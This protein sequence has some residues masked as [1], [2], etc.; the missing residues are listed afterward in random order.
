MKT[1]G[2]L[3]AQE[4]YAKA[5]LEP[6]EVIEEWNMDFHLGT[7]LCY[8]VRCQ[9]KGSMKLDLEKAVWYLRRRLP[10]TDDL[11]GR[12][13]TPCAKNH[14]FHDQDKILEAWSFLPPNLHHA[15]GLLLSATIWLD[16]R[17][18]ARDVRIAIQSIEAE[19]ASYKP[20]PCSRC[21]GA[22]VW[23]DDCAGKEYP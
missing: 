7:A 6:I 23:C 21:G 9:F 4:H 8:V 2:S 11:T 5:G 16:W 12:E 17:S 22:E 10:L 20:I 15:V 13:S 18:F 1:D 14:N 19:I 3:S